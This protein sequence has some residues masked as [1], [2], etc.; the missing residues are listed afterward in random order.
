MS[1]APKPPDPY[2]TAA[3]QTSSNQQTANYNAELNRVDTYTPYGNSVYTSTGTQSNPH[4]RQ[5]ISLTPE[6][7]SQVQNELKQN[8]T[9]SQLGFGLADQAKTNL[10]APLPDTT[11]SRDAAANAYYGRQTAY[12]DPQFNNER[13]DLKS[14][15]TN[16][17][18]MQGSAAYG[19][20]QDEQARHQA[21]SYDQ[22]RNQS[23]QVG[24]QAQQ[25]ALAN[26]LASRDMP[27]N[28]L[29]ALRTGT[30]V[31]N[32][33]FQ[34]QA[35]SNAGQ[36]DIAGLVEQNYAQRSA[37]ANNFNSGLFGLA[38]AAT[39]AL[40]PKPSDRR[41]K[42]D[43]EPVGK[44]RGVM[45]YAYKYLGG[46]Y[47]HVGVMAQEVP[48]AAVRQPDGYLFVDYGRI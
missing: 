38:G 27:L 32:P 10:S 26:A 12:L 18:V 42:T 20:A 25:T 45:L 19:R 14:D 5:D 21:F 34:G 47:T 37:N 2:A 1:K 17:G 28:E 3:A 24:D 29:N 48:W 39:S 30:Q 9:L 40:I 33:S 13:R 8:N 22:A 43:I 44:W 36:T 16:Q 31:N 35:Q 23:L 46:K 11:Q 15:L 6:A 7:A 41:L 4:W